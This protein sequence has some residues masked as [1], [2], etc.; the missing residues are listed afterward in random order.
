VRIAFSVVALCLALAGC[1]DTV[2]SFYPT[3][4]DA[5]AAQL[6]E[7]GWL[8]SIIPPSSHK[9]T[10]SNDLDSNI[11]N[12]DF[13]FD[14]S[15]GPA[16]LA[17]LKP[18]SGRRGSRDFTANIEKWKRKGYLPYEFSYEN[19]VWIFYIRQGHAAYEMWELEREQR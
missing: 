11:S 6:F 8:P 17:Q 19:T 1:S 3:R 7:R 14:G 13:Y 4:E 5:V 2:T 9:I 18:S 16:F 10:T 15:D 12:G